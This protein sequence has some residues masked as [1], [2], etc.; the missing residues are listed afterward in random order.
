MSLNCFFLLTFVVMQVFSLSY[1]PASG[2]I[3]VGLNIGQVKIVHV[4]LPAAP[5]AAQPT[6]H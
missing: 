5:Q 3:A 4:A 6:R 2:N 1:H